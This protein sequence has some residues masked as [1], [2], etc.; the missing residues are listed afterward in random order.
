LKKINVGI[1]R[2]VL[3]DP[4]V[5]DE[6]E[7]VKDDESGA[8]MGLV[9]LLIK[10]KL[11]KEQIF[12]L[13][14]DKLPELD[15]IHLKLILQPGYNSFG[16]YDFKKDMYANLRYLFVPDFDVRPVL[17]AVTKGLESA[18]LK[19]RGDVPCPDCP[20]IKSSLEEAKK[21]LGDLRKK[22]DL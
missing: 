15:P 7:R 18:E 2:I 17:A 3:I 8:I 10:Q 12:T 1:R 20:E 21:A 14:L 6:E 4:T 16:Y 5:E 19:R 13:P 9:N 22:E 11:P